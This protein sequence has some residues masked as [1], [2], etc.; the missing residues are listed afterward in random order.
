MQ[1][2]DMEKINILYSFS[3]DTWR[4]AAVSIESLLS[5]AKDTTKIAIYCMVE[6]RTKG[7]WK[8]RRIVKSHKN[9]AD[10]VWYKVNPKKNPFKDQEFAK[11]NPKSFYRCFAHR[12]FKKIDKI[13]YLSPDTLTYR[14]LSEL[15]NTD[16][17]DYV[18]GAV[19][20]MAPINDASNAL[21][22]YAKEFSEKYLNNGP[23]YN[24][25]V[26][27]FNLKKMAENEHLLFENKVPLRYPV[28]D[29]L[30]A[31]FAGKIKTLPLK[32]NLAP[33]VGV[34][35]HFS[36]EEAAEI[37]AGGHVILDCYYARPYDKE[38]ANKVTY[39][40]FEKCSEKIGMK[41]EAFLV[42]DKKKEKVRKT[43][44]PHIKVRGQ[45]LLFFGMEIK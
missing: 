30:N 42:A 34:P 1:V 40:M 2:F 19:P 24:G 21:G 18:L 36:A 27:L 45:I 15:F 16:I 28:Q 12:I 8:I 37:N 6:P 20:D 17:S 43:F 44:V 22:V 35:A 25:G 39:D 23:Y 5:S 31:S 32:Y 7:Y 4:M 41:P 13:L 26:L 11:N 3:K 9:G 29:L 14:D 33:G 10:L 38:R